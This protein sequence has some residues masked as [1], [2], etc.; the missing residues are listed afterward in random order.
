MN[1]TY[2]GS[3]GW[4]TPYITTNVLKRR[5]SKYVYNAHGRIRL[6]RYT[7]GADTFYTFGIT[8]VDNKPGHG[9]EW[10]SHSGY[11]NSIFGTNLLECAIKENNNV[12]FAMAIDRDSLKLPDNLT[13]K[14]SEIH[15]G[16]VVVNK[17]N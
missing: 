9:G 17:T 15:E 16:N 2:K 5:E 3:N 6:T 8:V 10:S 7:N 4:L 11:I 13:W 12:Y 14:Y 1:V